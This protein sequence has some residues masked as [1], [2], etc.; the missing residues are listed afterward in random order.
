MG[1][2]GSW[3]SAIKRVFTHSS[4]DKPT[5]GSDKKKKKD[6]GIRRPEKSK[7]LIPLFSEPSSIEKILGEA[8]Q[9]LIRPNIT[10]IVTT[11]DDSTNTNVTNNAIT[12]SSSSPPILPARPVSPRVPS[13][14]ATFSPPLK[15]LTSGVSS[16]SSSSEAFI[17]KVTTENKKEITNLP[18]PEPTLADQ[19]LSATKIQAVFRGYMARRSFRAA[20]GLVR[21]Q[22][23]LKGQNVKRQTANAMKQLQL[24][25]RVHTQIQSRKIRMLENQRQDYRNRNKDLESTLSKWTNQLSENEDWDDSLLTKEEVEARQRKKAEAVIKRERAMAYAYSH[26]SWK[27]NPSSSHG[28]LDPRTNGFPWWWNWL[29]RQLTDSK[30]APLTTTPPPPSGPTSE[31]GPSHRAHNNNGESSTPRSSRSRFPMKDNDDDGSFVS[32]PPFS[33]PSYM[34]PTVS[35]MAKARRFAGTRPESGSGRRF[36]FP[37]T[38]N[39]GRWGKV[40]PTQHDSTRSVG[41]F[42][43]GSATSM[44]ALVGRKPFNRVV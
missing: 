17:P 16:S 30:D 24:F 15:A 18:R 3:L 38:P 32:C 37:L 5:V 19:N 42:S 31:R 4:K 20:N 26:Q 29:D 41:E 25:V 12:R 13:P 11:Y 43:V 35:A 40:G 14:K 28:P 39:S 1:K 9:L 23:V 6:K 44:P 36:S 8:D 34:S 21:L 22:E 10:N 27:D 7:S 2:K 33:V